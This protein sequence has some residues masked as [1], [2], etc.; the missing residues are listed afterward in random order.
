MSDL[1]ISKS[2]SLNTIN[3]YDKLTSYVN[4]DTTIDNVTDTL[5][6]YGVAVIPNIL[7]NQ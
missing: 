3:N 4:Y 6:E 2:I 5:K 1:K 7:N